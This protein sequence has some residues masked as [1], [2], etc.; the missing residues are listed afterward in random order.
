LP[1][2]NAALCFGEILRSIQRIADFIGPM[3]FEQYSVDEKTASA[4]E[5]QLLIVTEASIRLSD[6]DRELCP[7]VEWQDMRNLGNRIRHAY[8]DID[9]ELIW[10]IV[11][12]DLPELK[13]K[14]EK[15]LHD[16]FP[17]VKLP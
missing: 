2:R 15:T 7:G 10:N 8:H 13:R 3:S 4:V 5:R 6:E 16:H 17:V 12:E 14:V 1:S 9:N 11:H